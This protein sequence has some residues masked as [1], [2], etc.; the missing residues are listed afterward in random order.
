MSSRNKGRFDK[1][2]KLL[3]QIFFINSIFLLIII[4]I[5]RVFWKI[6]ISSSILWTSLLLI[7]IIF[8]VLGIGLLRIREI[9]EFQRREEALGIVPDYI[10]PNDGIPEWEDIRDEIFKELQIGEYYHLPQKNQISIAGC[11]V[12][13]LPIN[14]NQLVLECPVCNLKAHR[15]H[16]LEWI[17]IKGFCPRCG[18]KL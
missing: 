1:Y 6:H 5:L 3:G 2:L 15:D 17:K 4:V 7:T 13:Q 9:Y 18:H 8:C 14:E 11:I 16:L 10:P 12:C